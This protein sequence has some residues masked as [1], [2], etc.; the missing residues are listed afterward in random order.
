MSE[1]KIAAR[2]EKAEPF[3]LK[4]CSIPAGVTKLAQLPF[5]LDDSG[6]DLEKIAKIGGEGYT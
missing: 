2:P 4:R 1:A 6:A 3:S 5:R